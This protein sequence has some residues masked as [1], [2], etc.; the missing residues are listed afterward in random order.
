MKITVEI[1]RDELNEII[2]ESSNYVASDNDLRINIIDAIDG[3]LSLP[4]YD[5]EVNVID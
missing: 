5:V 2:E 1:S 3:T 4:G